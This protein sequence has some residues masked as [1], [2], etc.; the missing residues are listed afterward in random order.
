MDNNINNVIKNVLNVQMEKFST[1]EDWSN[2]TFEDFKQTFKD[3]RVGEL[4]HMMEVIY[5]LSHDEK[6]MERCLSLFA[7]VRE[8]GYEENPNG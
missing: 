1:S 7:G 8:D 2:M 3:W 6:S 5:E 4:E